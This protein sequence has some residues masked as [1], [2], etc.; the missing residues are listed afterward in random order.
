MIPPFISQIIGVLVR[1]ALVWLAGYLNSHGINIGDS[2]VTQV[3][4][5]ATPLVAALAWSAYQKFHGRQKLLTAQAAA[6]LTEHE[7][8]ARVAD[9][10]TP[11]PSV[12]TP[13][14]EVPQ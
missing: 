2:Q 6:N 1:A 10:K 9:P 8:E 4:T 14:S 7:V 5:W 11:N 3:V 12:M 13:K